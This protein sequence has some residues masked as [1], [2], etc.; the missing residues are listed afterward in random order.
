MQKSLEILSKDPFPICV[1]EG[2][3]KDDIDLKKWQQHLDQ[4]GIKHTLKNS[5][6][7]ASVCLYRQVTPE[8]TEEIKEGKWIIRGSSFKVPA[9]LI[10]SKSSYMY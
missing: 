1:T 6:G 8:E 2:L 4:Q 7:S 3:F 9:R 5:Q 10:T